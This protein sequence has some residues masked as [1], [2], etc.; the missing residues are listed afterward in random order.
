MG[1]I[2]ELVHS[3]ELCVHDI[4]V[5]MVMDMR[6]ITQEPGYDF[7]ITV[8]V[9]NQEESLVC[10]YQ[11]AVPC[12]RKTLADMRNEMMGRRV[13]TLKDH[14]NRG[15]HPIRGKFVW[16]ELRYKISMFTIRLTD[17]YV[18]KVIYLL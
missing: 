18:C 6:V 9:V 7:E 13:V 15:T 14:L 12:N 17:Q 10:T 11:V 3:S 8:Q 1:V 5:G 4:V 16:Q 2:L